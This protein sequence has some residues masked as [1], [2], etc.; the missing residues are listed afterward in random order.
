MFE[1]GM[2][3]VKFEDGRPEDKFKVWCDKEDLTKPLCLQLLFRLCDTKEIFELQ[4]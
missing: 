1:N 2:L 3:I 4:E